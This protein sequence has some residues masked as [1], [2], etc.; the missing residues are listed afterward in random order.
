MKRQGERGRGWLPK[1]LREKSTSL[2][3][4]DLLVIR[5]GWVVRDLYFDLVLLALFILPFSNCSRWG[6]RKLS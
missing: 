5:G 2:N 4:I 3:N 6:G 1:M